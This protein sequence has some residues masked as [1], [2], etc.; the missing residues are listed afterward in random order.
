MIRCMM[1]RI[2]PVAVLEGQPSSLITILI[3]HRQGGLA[4]GA[5]AICI[6]IQPR[7]PTGPTAGEDKPAFEK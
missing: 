5:T 4:G 6:H 2:C 7:L 3:A 1:Q